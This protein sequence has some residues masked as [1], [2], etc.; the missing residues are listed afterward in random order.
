MGRVIRAIGWLLGGLVV[1]LAAVWIVG[2]RE[3]VDTSI[4]FDPA[5]VPADLDGWLADRE[6]LVPDLEPTAA[7]RIAWAAGPGRRTDLAIVVLHGFSA[8]PWEIRPVP[9]RV[10]EALRAN[11]FFQRLA[12]HGR[13]GAAMAEPSAGD[14]LE[15]LAEAMEVGRRIGDRVIV[16]GTST[17]GTLAGALVADPALAEL[18][19]GLAGVVLISPNFKVKN[20]AAAL[21]SLPAARTW[22]PWIAG[23]TRSFTPQNERHGRHWTTEYPTVAALPMQ[24]LVGHVS[25]LDWAEVEVPGLFYFSPDDQVVDAETSERIASAWGG[26]VAVRRVDLGAGDDPFNHVIAGDIL[27]PGQTPDAI[28]TIARWIEGL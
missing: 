21:L 5:T 9:E 15:D 1:V 23:E 27:S 25:A 19:D 28:A 16:I 2:A 26:P 13:D 7:K 8:S 6:A 14:W 18:R 24:A 22:V 10:G 12:G 20:P 11:V 3:E 4:G 17:G